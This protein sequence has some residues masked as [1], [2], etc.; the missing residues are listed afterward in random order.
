MATNKQLSDGIVCE[1]Y[2]SCTFTQKTMQR[3]IFIK[4]SA[5]LSAG[6]GTTALGLGTAGCGGSSQSSTEADS[7][8]TASNGAA[9]PI[10]R[11]SLAEWSF[12]K[13][14][15]NPELFK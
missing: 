3:R 1:F 7:T 2:E 9:D 11:I 4:C 10:Y 5:L 14:L 8:A 15:F 6:I 13:A 12:H